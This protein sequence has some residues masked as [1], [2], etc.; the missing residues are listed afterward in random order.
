MIK[1]VTEHWHQAT[2]PIDYEAPADWSTSVLRRPRLTSG[3]VSTLPDIPAAPLWRADGAEGFL[4][5]V[6]G[7]DALAACVVWRCADDHSVPLVPVR[8]Q[9]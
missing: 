1:E 5:Q 6:H 7:H 3:Q 9:R 2:W 4:H 8:G